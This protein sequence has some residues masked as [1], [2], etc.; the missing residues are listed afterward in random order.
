MLDT[1]VQA[2]VNAYDG[3]TQT[4]GSPVV[5]LALAATLVVLALLELCVKKQAEPATEAN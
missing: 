5:L 4:F 1:L 2:A 3:Y